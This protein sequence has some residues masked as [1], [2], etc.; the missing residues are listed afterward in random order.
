MTE[1]MITAE[2]KRILQW[3]RDSGADCGEII[4]VVRGGQIKFVDYRGR[5]PRTEMTAARENNYNYQ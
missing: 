1:E 5:V 3:L 4:L 2:V